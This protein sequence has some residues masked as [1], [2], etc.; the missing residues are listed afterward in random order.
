M[1]HLCAVLA[2]KLPLLISEL[3]YVSFTCSFCFACIQHWAQIE[4]RCPFCKSRFTTVSRKVLDL[5]KLP[6]S[7][8]ESDDTVRQRF[9]GSV[10]ETVAIPERNQVCTNVLHALLGLPM[11]HVWPG[12]VLCTPYCYA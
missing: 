2:Q 4:S 10:L 7:G 12:C 11:D 3:K 8:A 6:D 1:R 5:D 9:P